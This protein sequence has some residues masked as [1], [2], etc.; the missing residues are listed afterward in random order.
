MSMSPI[1]M[2]R[3]ILADAGCSSGNLCQAQPASNP[4]SAVSCCNSHRSN[5]K[6]LAQSFR[7]LRLP[8]F[9][10]TGSG[11]RWLMKSCCFRLSNSRGFV[12]P[13][14]SKYPMS[15]GGRQSISSAN[16]ALRGA[17]QEP[18]TQSGA[19][20]T[21]GVTGGACPL[22]EPNLCEYAQVN[23]APNKKICAE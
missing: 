20:G 1:Q 16:G 12:V 9:Q 2:A 18:G 19:W 21:A 3:Q 8:T 22:R 13:P 5:H 7:V 6:C 11:Y 10:N 14:S 17:T 23:S 4:R 15:N